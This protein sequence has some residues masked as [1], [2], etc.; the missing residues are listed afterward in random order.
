MSINEY[1]VIDEILDK[2]HDQE[3]TYWI[4][5][6]AFYTYSIF[7]TWW[8]VY[9]N[10][11]LIQ[12]KQAIIDLQE[13]NQATVSNIYSLSL[14]LDI[15]VSILSCKYISMINETDFFYQ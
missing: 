7:V 1:A 8:T 6:S 4:Q 15:I 3:K 9:K 12:K 5:S 10:E 11:K 2:L 14:Q 13:L